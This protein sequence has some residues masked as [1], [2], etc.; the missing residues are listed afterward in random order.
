M[1]N[2]GAFIVILISSTLSAQTPISVYQGTFT[3]PSVS[4]D[5]LYFAFAKGDQVIVDF[6]SIG[7][8]LKEFEML[9]W[10][11]GSI[12]REDD[13]TKILGKK[14]SIEATSIYQFRLANRS[15]TERNCKLHI[16][17][18]PGSTSTKNFKTTV[19]W[20]TENDTIYAATTEKYLT[21]RDTAIVN[22]ES[23]LTVQGTQSR[24]G[25]T[26]QCPEFSLPGKI[27][28]WSFYIGVNRQAQQ[29]Y[30]EAEQRF[31]QTNATQ[32]MKIP[33]YGLMA[34]FALTGK[35]YFT[36]IQNAQAI[37]YSIVD[38]TNAALAKQQQPFK[39]IRSKKVT[40]DFSAMKDPITDKCYFYL[41]N[42][43]DAN[44]DVWIKV[45]AV[46]IYEKWAER[47]GKKMEILKRKVPVVAAR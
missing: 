13:K 8:E 21:R 14:I 41:S 29:V 32:Q 17:R 35:S 16:R 4:E 15:A 18:I 44:L 30:K 39:S 6:E 10:P 23:A 12:F 40:N 2:I 26:T 43:T 42:G 22:R 9:Q 46:V 36:P 24:Y 47:P 25:S 33:G 38:G 5:T 45:A 7:R 27:I 1:K 20:K 37:T 31:A 19:A 11:R 34:A 28:A 3:I